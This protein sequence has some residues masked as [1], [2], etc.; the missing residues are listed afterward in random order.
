M[1]EL[2]LLKK[3]WKRSDNQYKSFSDSDIYKMSH[4][5]SST[6]VKTLFY[7]SVAE[8][9]FWVLINFLPYV[10][11]EKMKAQLEEMSHSWIYVSLN[12]I[13]YLVIILF[14]Y[15]LWR[16]H[17]AISVTDN[18]K[19]LMES[20]LKTRKIIKYYVLYN[21][22]IALISIPISLYFSINEHPEISEQLSNA[23]TEKLVI[24][25]LVAIGITIA[26]L[27]LVW[28]FYKLIYGILI[29]RLNRNY[30]ELKKLEI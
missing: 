30:Q 12:I 11:S 24:M 1:D 16:A 5:K 18:A 6:I 26:F 29:R 27:G 14:V 2:E 23:T 20:I 25:S 7:I 28:L 21:L 17:K 8:L 10:L 19:K 4:K 9:V 22:S 13:S 15:L 3:D